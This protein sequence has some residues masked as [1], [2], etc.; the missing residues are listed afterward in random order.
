MTV[1]ETLANRALKRKLGVG[2]LRPEGLLRHKKSTE[3]WHGFLVFVQDDTGPDAF[4]E[5]T[6]KAMLAGA[7]TVICSAEMDQSHAAMIGLLLDVSLTPRIVIIVTLPRHHAA[8]NRKVELL[9]GKGPLIHVV[10][11][12]ATPEDW[13]SAQ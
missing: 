11:E 5:D 9:S 12:D 1:T 7:Q 4:K 2:V 10:T 8:W 13:G 3:T 6:L